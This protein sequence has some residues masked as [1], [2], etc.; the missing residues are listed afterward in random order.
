MAFESVR[1]YGF[2]GIMTSYGGTK[3]HVSKSKKM[4]LCQVFFSNQSCYTI[5]EPVGKYGLGG[6]YDIV[7]HTNCHV[8]MSR[9]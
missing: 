3:W 4:K 2:K 7:W 8:S 6:D 1:K 9:K 5:F